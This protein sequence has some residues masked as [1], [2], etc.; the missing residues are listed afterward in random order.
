MN[1]RENFFGLSEEV[2]SGLAEAFDS[3]TEVDEVIIFGSR[4]KGNHSEGSDI[5]LAAKGRDVTLDTI[6]DIK[7][8]IEELG[9][10]YRVDVLNYH[11]IRDQDVVDHIDRAGKVF[12]KRNGG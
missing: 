8:K 5:D 9:L 12:W 10:L 7:I 1:V 2:I 11:G 3:A 4:A 6:L